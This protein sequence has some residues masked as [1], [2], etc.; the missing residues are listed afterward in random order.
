MMNANSHF[1]TLGYSLIICTVLCTHIALPGD[2]GGN[3]HK[4]TRGH[5]MQ[6][7]GGPFHSKI[8]TCNLSWDWPNR[9]L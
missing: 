1:G 2:F 3:A 9:R 4:G 5:S 6:S 7:F 8:P